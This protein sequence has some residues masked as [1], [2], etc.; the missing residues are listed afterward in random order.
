MSQEI[1]EVSTKSLAIRRVRGSKAM[2][3]REIAREYRGGF[4]GFPKGLPFDRNGNFIS[5]RN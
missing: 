5:V 1:R 3:R 2:R 4:R